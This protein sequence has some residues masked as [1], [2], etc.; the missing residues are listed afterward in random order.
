VTLTAARRRL[1]LA[2]AAGQTLKAHRD[3]DGHKQFRLHPA[4]GG[5][6]EPVDRRVA[7][8]LAEAGLIDSNKKFPAATFWLTEAGRQAA[9][10]AALELTD[11][12]R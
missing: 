6:G 10:V 3:I 5:P 4:E 7:E 2:L 9:A 12:R 1:L 8:A 11:D